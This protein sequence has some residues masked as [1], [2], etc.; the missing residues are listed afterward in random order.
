VFGSKP[1]LLRTV[2]DQALAGDDESVPVAQRDWFRP[3]WRAR[4][5]AGV[6]AAYAK[7]CTIIGERAAPHFEVVRQAQD[8]A[9]D[10]AELWHTLVENRRRGAAMVVDCAR[11]SG[12]LRPGLSRERAIDRLWVFNDPAHYAALVG[13]CAWSRRDFQ[14]WLTEQMQASLLP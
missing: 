9:A 11:R 14:R 6:L 4:T 12:S 8:D 1:A 10:A 2:L 3:V 5:P 13:G 7:V